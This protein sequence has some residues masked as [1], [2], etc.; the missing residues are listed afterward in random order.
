MIMTPE[1]NELE[2]APTTPSVEQVGS[3]ALFGVG[4]WNPLDAGIKGMSLMV[5]AHEYNRV[6]SNLADAL[7]LALQYV[8]LEGEDAGKIREM[9]RA[10][11]I[12]PNTE[13]TDAAKNQNNTEMIDKPS[14][15]PALT[16][17]AGSVFHVEKTGVYQGSKLVVSVWPSRKACEDRMEGESWLDMRRRTDSDR[18][19]IELE[20]KRRAQEICDFLNSQNAE[21]SRAE[22][23]TNE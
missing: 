23:T 19:E 1:N 17:A 7:L 2:S 6:A 10:A 14:A 5:P 12:P 9:E 15:D 16:A 22:R 20:T 3:T 11:T 8:P 21:D 4:V 18:L 13:H